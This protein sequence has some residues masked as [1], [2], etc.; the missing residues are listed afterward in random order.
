MTTPST[1]ISSPKA[2][3]RRQ[4]RKSLDAKRRKMPIIDV[5]KVPLET[6]EQHWDRRALPYFV[7]LRVMRP[8]LLAAVWLAAIGYAWYQLK[9]INESSSVLAELRLYGMIVLVMLVSAVVFALMRNRSKPAAF[10]PQERASV[11]EVAEFA[12]LPPQRLS[13]W[14]DL[15]LVSVEHDDH[16]RVVSARTVQ[17]GHTRTAPLET[18]IQTELDERVAKVREKRHDLQSA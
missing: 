14:Q 15:S 3:P 10:A 12:D 9:D 8:L 16:G 1:P 4:P 13:A 6:M 7:W 2:S 11:R 18:P 17:P 5:A